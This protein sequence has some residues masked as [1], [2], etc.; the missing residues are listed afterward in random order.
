M[1]NSSHHLCVGCSKALATEAES[2]VVN[3][4]VGRLLKS[5]IVDGRRRRGRPRRSDFRQESTWGL[6]HLMCFLRAIDSADGV[7]AELGC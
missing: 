2:K 3:V 7:F 4:Q 6:M 1:M 5:Q